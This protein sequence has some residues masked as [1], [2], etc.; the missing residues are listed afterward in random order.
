MWTVGVQE[1]AKGMWQMDKVVDDVEDTHGEEF[2]VFTRV[3][4]D[5]SRAWVSGT[6]TTGTRVSE[7]ENV[8]FG[9][10]V[11]YVARVCIRGVEGSATVESVLLEGVW[12]GR[13]VWNV[14]VGKR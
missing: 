12:M 6:S 7:R 1:T 11:E 8:M 9:R 5:G 3:C 13:E 10:C 4:C 2:S 14:D